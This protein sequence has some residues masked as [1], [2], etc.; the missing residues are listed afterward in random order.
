MLKSSSSFD[1]LIEKA[2]S[3]LLLDPDWSTI[4]AICDMIRQNDVQASQAV[5]SVKKRLIHQNPHVVLLALNVLE[6]MVKNCGG[7]VHDEVA[8]SQFMQELYALVTRSPDVVRDKLLQMLQTWAHAFRNSPRY[9]SVQ[10]T[11]KLMR[12]EGYKFPAL[13]VSDAMFAVEMAPA[14]LDGDVCHRCRVT[15]T[16]FNRKHHCRA[17]GQVFC[18]KCSSK[19][20]NI[21]KLGIE[22]EVRVCDTC[23]DQINKVGTTASAPTIQSRPASSSESDLPPEYLASPLSKQSQAPPSKS[24]KELKEQEELNLALAISQSEAEAKER[25]RGKVTKRQSSGN[26]TVD[27]GNSGAS[28]RKSSLKKSSIERDPVADPE[29][30]RYLDRS[31]WQAKQQQQQKQPSVDIEGATEQQK[32][33]DGRSINGDTAS[34]DYPSISAT[35]STASTNEQESFTGQDQEIDVFVPNLCSHLEIFVNRMKSNSSRGRPISNDTSVQSMFMN[36]TSLHAQLLQYLQGQDDRRVHYEW[37]QDRLSQ[38]RDARAALDSLREEHRDQQRRQAE[39]VQ[40]LRQIQMMQKLEI[41]RQKKHEYLQYQR[42]MAMQ[43][44]QDQEREMARRYEQQQQ[45]QVMFPQPQQ[46]Q[47]MWP[48]QQQQPHPYQPMW[49]PQLQPG[50]QPQSQLP[51]GVQVPTQLQPGLQPPTQP[52]QFYQPQQPLYQPQAQMV[53]PQAQIQPMAQPQSQLPSLA[54]QQPLHQPSLGQL[55]PQEQAMIPGYMPG[56]PPVVDGGVTPAAPVEMTSTGSE[57]FNMSA[58]ANMLPPS[59]YGGMVPVTGGPMAGPTPTQIGTIPPGPYT[60]PAGTMMAPVS[61]PAIQQQ[62]QLNTGYSTTQAPPIDQNPNQN[63]PGVTNSV[64]SVAP[65]ISFD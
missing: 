56:P 9:S 61:N 5:V 6:A 62:Q 63:S 60:V 36:I 3:H 7:P 10:D 58:M 27:S 35:V 34:T 24:E 32:Q 59:S 46:Q 15:F 64:E 54:N 22:R 23:F 51:P 29:L 26:S 44:I 25:E 50:Q 18:S 45:Q 11:V 49:Q 17:C 48:Q 39:E 2:T 12:A 1:K 16:T 38:V 13:R 57:A 43:R 8:N 30:A 21:P 42:Q 52:H 47:Y 40:R 19:V 33:H 20:S 31:Y 65:L 37:L 53:Q 14:W 41:M 55:Q 28:T 4:L